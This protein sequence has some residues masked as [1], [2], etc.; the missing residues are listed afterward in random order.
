[1]DKAQRQFE[2]L[3]R[4]AGLVLIRATRHYVYRAADGRKFVC[5]RSHGGDDPRTTRNRL[6]SL[7]RFLTAPVRCNEGRNR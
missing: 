6:A 1:M 2:Q 3:I 4:D 5:S 7:R